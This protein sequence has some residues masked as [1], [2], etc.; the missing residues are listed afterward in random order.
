M[1]KH[2]YLFVICSLLLTSMHLYAFDI[3]K[4]IAGVNNENALTAFPYRVFIDSVNLEDIQ[5]LMNHKQILD[6]L[7][8]PGEKILKLAL[9]DSLIE[10]EKNIAAKNPVAYWKKR[11]LFGVHFRILSEYDTVNSKLFY[12]IS[13]RWLT[14]ISEQISDSMS[15]KHSL[16]YSNEIYYISSTLEANHY[17]L[18]YPPASSISKMITNI[19]QQRWYYLWDRFQTTP[20]IFR[21]GVFAALIIILLENIYIFYQIIKKLKSQKR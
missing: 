17:Y 16:Q 6:S 3:R 4:H 15:R 20:L 10:F 14:L 18:T 8:L 11:M 13:R 19:S 2:C 5:E 12:K 21:V 7:N 1:K 9:A